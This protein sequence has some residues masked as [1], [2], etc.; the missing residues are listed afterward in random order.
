[1]TEKTESMIHDAKITSWGMTVK[2][3]EEGDKAI[4]NASARGEVNSLPNRK[5]DTS[6]KDH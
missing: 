3:D 2:I 1:M 5:Y 4:D 6:C